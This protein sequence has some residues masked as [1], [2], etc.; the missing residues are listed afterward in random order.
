MRNLVFLFG[1]LFSLAACSNSSGSGNESPRLTPFDETSK[2]ILK[3]IM[4]SFGKSNFSLNN[5]IERL[6]LPGSVIDDGQSHIGIGSY[7]NFVEEQPFDPEDDFMRDIEDVGC[8]FDFTEEAPLEHEQGSLPTFNFRS[9]GI[10][11]PMSVNMRVAAAVEQEFNIAVDYSLG[12][13]IFDEEMKQDAG[14]EK[15][16]MNGRISNEFSET[17]DGGIINNVGIRLETRAT[18]VQHGTVYILSEMSVR[19]EMSPGMNDGGDFEVV[20]P[21]A[22]NEV[23]FPFTEDASESG[24]FGM[25]QVITEKQTVNVGTAIAAQFESSIRIEGFLNITAI[26]K[27][28]GREVTAD[29]YQTYVNEMQVPGMDEEDEDDFDTGNPFPPDGPF[30]WPDEPVGEVLMSCSLSFYEAADVSLSELEDALDRNEIHLIPAIQ[31]GMIHEGTETEP[32]DP[33]VVSLPNSD[34]IK[35]I[36]EARPNG[37]KTLIYQV[38]DGPNV[39]FD[40]EPNAPGESNKLIHDIQPGYFS[41]AE[42]W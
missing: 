31:F 15:S 11:C 24:F 9:L 1:I 28:N 14:F 22:Q 25:K 3:D 17:T 32:Y 39:G 33:I 12:Y 20:F 35:V 29:E 7:N 10:D 36:L 4:Q 6:R 18:H 40:F 30:P 2:P 37:E 21:N 19:V 13:E 27:I 8:R 23:P 34:Q 16:Q 5:Q 26:Y 38:N 41:Y 42:C